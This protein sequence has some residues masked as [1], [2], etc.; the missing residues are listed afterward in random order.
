MVC[1]WMTQLILDP[2]YKSYLESLQAPIERPVLEPSG[3]CVNEQSLILV[4]NSQPTSTPLLEYLRLQSIPGFKS[5]KKKQ[6][7]DSSSTDVARNAAVAAVTASAAKRTSKDQGV[8]IAGKGRA[9]VV[10]PI[11]ETPAKSASSEKPVGKSRNRKPKAAKGGPPTDNIPPPSITPTN[12]PALGDH[13]AIPST[14]SSRLPPLSVNKLDGGG[15]ASVPGRGAGHGALPREGGRGRGGAS[16]GASSRG[17]G[18][19]ANAA[20]EGGAAERGGAR[21]AIVNAP[22]QVANSD[23]GGSSQTTPGRGRGRGKGRGGGETR[24]NT[25]RETVTGIL[26]RDPATGKSSVPTPRLARIDA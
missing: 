7:P 15:V 9:V 25:A 21:G 20:R 17:R 3:M 22:D 11:K 18:V 26:T 12:F 14:S 2:D 13:S 4:P 8:M 19:T 24:D 23:L 10:A 16:R 1:K 5:G 6:K